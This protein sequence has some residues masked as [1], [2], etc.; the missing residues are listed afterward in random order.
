MVILSLFRNDASLSSNN[1]NKKRTQ[2]GKK[3]SMRV[4][5]IGAL[6]LYALSSQAQEGP[7]EGL[8]MTLDVDQRFG[9]DTKL[10]FAGF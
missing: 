4:A 3:Q 6:G 9:I 1:N 7:A 2:V 10:I 5:A 8:A